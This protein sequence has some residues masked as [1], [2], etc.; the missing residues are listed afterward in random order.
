ME[1]RETELEFREVVDAREMEF[2][3]EG[4]GVDA[5]SEAEV[6]SFARRAASSV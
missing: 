5:T 1:P 6:P 4:G 2:G 3:F